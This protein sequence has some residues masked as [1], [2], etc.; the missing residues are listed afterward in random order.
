M[1]TLT[2]PPIGKRI[3]LPPRD[4]YYATFHQAAQVVVAMMLGYRVD[5]V[6]IG[7]NPDEF[8]VC[9]ESANADD[10]DTVCAAGYAMEVL[11]NRRA[12]TAWDQSKTDRLRMKSLHGDHTG[13]VLD[14]AA[15]KERFMAGAELCRAILNHTGARQAIDLLA[16]ALS[17]AYLAGEGRL[18]AAAIQ[19]VTKSLRESSTPL[20]K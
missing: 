7:V 5:N 17:E 18:E 16:E 2:L 1:S 4:L 12:D 13:I 8:G 20:Q 3:T 9:L 11:L 6:D 19:E 10:I 15:T 14:L